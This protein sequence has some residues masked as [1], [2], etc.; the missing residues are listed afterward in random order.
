[1]AQ[2]S[3][4]GHKLAVSIPVVRDLIEGN[5]AVTSGGVL[6]VVA[7]PIGN[8]DDI[9]SR[10]REILGAVSLIAAEDTRHS[11]Q[12]LARLNIRTELISFHDHNERDRVD[13]IVQRLVEGANV[14]L[15]S[16]AGTPLVSDP[17]FRLV[18]AARE[19]GLTVRPIPGCCAAIAALSAAGLPSDHFF[20]E[21]FLPVRGRDREA[22]LAYLA[23]CEHT[24]IL[25]ESVHRI[26][27]TLSDLA[28][29]LG[30]G[31]RAVL[32]RELTKLHETFYSGTLG[33][34]SSKLGDDPGGNKGEFTLVIG[35][36][37]ADDSPRYE[38]ARVVAAIGP[39][40]PPGQAASIVA[41]ITGCTRE[42]AYAAI[43][44]AKRPKRTE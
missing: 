37:P 31:R 3:Q 25:Y 34:I 1:M 19:H 14:A 38:L 26:A 5:A 39:A 21:G 36:A 16:D 35:G 18:A 7:T 2:S 29:A 8:V 17:G 27:G 30:S 42:V 11:G 20:F 9:S 24:M 15:I 23:G 13:S 4:R 12:L 32:A 44:H 41:A 6:Y 28:E 33:E 10:A 40:L 43:A 22:R